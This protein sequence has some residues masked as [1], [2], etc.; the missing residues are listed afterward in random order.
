VVSPQLL[1][2]FSLLLL[3][4]NPV[5]SQ[6]FPAFSLLL[7]PIKAASLLLLGPHLVLNHSF[8]PIPN[9]EK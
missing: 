4:F 5:S 1:Q 8:A 9:P 2:T 6:L 7:L 3:H